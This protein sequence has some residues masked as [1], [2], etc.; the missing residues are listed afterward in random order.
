MSTHIVSLTSTLAA[1]S[2]AFCFHPQ[3]LAQDTASAQQEMPSQLVL[4]RDRG[5]RMTVPVTIDG[6]GPYQ[7]LV[8]TGAERT[9]ISSELARRL[10]LDAGTSVRMH[11]MTEVGQVS[12]AL[13]PQLKVDQRV[14]RDIHAPALS[15]ADIGAAGML[16]VDSLKSQRVVFDFA[17]GT[18][19]ITPSQKR[20]ERWDGDSI[21][22]KGRSLYGR[23]VLVDARLDGQKIMVILDTGSQVSIGNNA[24][25]NK[26]KGRKKLGS[27]VPVE[28]TSVTG[29]R[30][31]ADYTTA[32]RITIGGVTIEDMPIAFAEVHPFRQMQLTD[33]PAILLGM[34]VLRLFERVSVDFARR[35]VRFLSPEVSEANKADRMAKAAPRREAVPRPDAFPG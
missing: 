17:K 27:T 7:F 14:I 26:L 6:S 11:S 24:L 12:T 21:V 34:D 3:V 35:E 15:A 25:R 2:L 28:L 10:E 4:E 20:Q 33:Q 23:L 31:I 32:K 29:G 30:M 19:S 13:I 18:M 9:V 22:V 5:S 1:A 16:G 8:D